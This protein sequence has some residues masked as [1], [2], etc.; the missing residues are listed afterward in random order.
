MSSI[1]GVSSLH[2]PSAA[3]GTSFS[4]SRFTAPSEGIVDALAPPGTVVDPVN[5][6]GFASNEVPSDTPVSQ[7]GHFFTVYR[8]DSAPSRGIEHASMTSISEPA[9]TSLIL[10]SEE[11]QAGHISSTLPTALRPPVPD[12]P[13]DLPSSSRLPPVQVGGPASSHLLEVAILGTVSSGIRCSVFV[14]DQQKPAFYPNLVEL[15]ASALVVL[16]AIAN[17]LPSLKHLWILKPPPSEMGIFMSIASAIRSSCRLQS[18][19]LMCHSTFDRDLINVFL[20]SAQGLEIFEC[21]L[22][23]P[24]PVEICLASIYT[25]AFCCAPVL[26]FLTLHTSEDSAIQTLKD[27][28]TRIAYAAVPSWRVDALPDVSVQLGVY[29]YTSVFYIKGESLLRYKS[30]RSVA[31]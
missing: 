26:K 9:S 2:R 3:G 4:V 16:G 19:H 1:S 30:I 24:L 17:V 22:A 12:R 23:S 8:L 6:A 29:P 13:N 27:R 21:V 10:A 18:L 31:L 14:G 20:E 28:H 25:S 11:E 15:H 5:R 7:P